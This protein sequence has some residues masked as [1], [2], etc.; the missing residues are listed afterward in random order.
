MEFSDI[1]QKRILKFLNNLYVIEESLHRDFELGHVD[2]VSFS[3]MLREIVDQRRNL[4]KLIK[5]TIE[6]N[7]KKANEQ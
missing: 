1:N 2:R 4:Y 5:A 3:R 7:Q 6:V